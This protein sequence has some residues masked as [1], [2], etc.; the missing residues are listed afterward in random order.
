MIEKKN[1]AFWQI[2]LLTF[3]EDLDRI[4]LVGGDLEENPAPH[5]NRLLPTL[6]WKKY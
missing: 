6:S 2:I 1:Q 5:R 4:G 3:G